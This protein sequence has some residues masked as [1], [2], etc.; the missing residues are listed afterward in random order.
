MKKMTYRLVPSLLA[1]SLALFSVA[2]G[3]GKEGLTAE[4]V[5]LEECKDLFGEADT[6]ASSEALDEDSEEMLPGD[7][8]GDGDEDEDDEAIKERC[9]E[10]MAEDEASEDD[11]SEAE[12]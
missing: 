2:C 4:N 6:E 3:D 11:D 5:T 10:L 7:Y 1:L 8:D 12:S 9:E